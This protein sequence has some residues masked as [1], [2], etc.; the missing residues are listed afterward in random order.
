MRTIRFPSNQ[1][2]HLNPQGQDCHGASFVL[3]QVRKPAYNCTVECTA[4]GKKLIAYEGQG[5][6]ADSLVE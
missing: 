5:I 1:A 4:C 2:K 6:T 3:K